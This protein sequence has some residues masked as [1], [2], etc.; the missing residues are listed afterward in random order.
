MS[1]DNNGQTFAS[2]RL[3]SQNLDSYPLNES[4][5]LLSHVSFI[6]MAYGTVWAR[7]EA[8]VHYPSDV[9]FGA[10]LGNFMATFFYKLLID[11]D[12]ENLDVAFS[13]IE[14]EF[15]ARFCIRY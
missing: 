6:S 2:A 1:K 11:E 4:V 5:K 9:L 12:N 3:A 13:L 8:N 7:V 15:A 10:A 14:D